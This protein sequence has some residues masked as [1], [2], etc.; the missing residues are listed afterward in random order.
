[1]IQ[2]MSNP[3]RASTEKMRGPDDLS[4]P[5]RAA[6]RLSLSITGPGLYRVPAGGLLHGLVRLL[7][8]LVERR[9]EELFAPAF[10]PVDRLGLRLDGLGV[11]ALGGVDLGRGGVGH[12]G[13]VAAGSGGLLG[14]AQ[15]QVKVDA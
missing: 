2:N 14:Q 12:R 8:V 15:R 6:V 13:V 4:S 7:L 5:A 9:L 3:R 10:R 1:M 11:I